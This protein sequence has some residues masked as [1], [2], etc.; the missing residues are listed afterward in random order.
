M[1]LVERDRRAR[2]IKSLLDASHGNRYNE[3]ET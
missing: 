2:R 3:R 1:L